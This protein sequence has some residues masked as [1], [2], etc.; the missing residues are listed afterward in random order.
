MEK[1]G[2]RI[3]Y[4]HLKPAEKFLE[5]LR[6]LNETFCLQ[7]IH[8]TVRRNRLQSAYIPAVHKKEKQDRENKES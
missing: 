8:S 4:K 5:K 3:R 7:E 2:S 1:F 6:V